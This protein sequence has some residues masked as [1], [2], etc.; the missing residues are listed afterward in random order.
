M[1]FLCCVFSAL[2]CSVTL[3][4]EYSVLLLFFCVLYCSFSLYCTVSACDVR[5]ATLRFLRAFS[6]VVRQMPGYN[7]QRRGTART[8]QFFSCYCYVCMF[9]SVYS[10]YCLCVNVYCTAV[11]RCQPNCSYIS[12][13]II[14]YRIINY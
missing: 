1:T 8:S 4:Y 3:Y 10:V 14:S 2:Y 12:Y 13:H 6:S 9:R 5:A 7:S 11:I